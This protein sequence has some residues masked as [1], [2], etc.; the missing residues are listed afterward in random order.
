MTEIAITSTS[1]ESYFHKALKILLCEKILEMNDSIIEH[2]QEKYIKKRF[3]DIY[4][5]FFNGK[6][7]VVEIQN[8]YISV[9]EIKKRIKDYNDL[10]I[11]VLWILYG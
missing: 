5:K 9:S 1:S 2:S 10:G 7:V 4:F 6:E 3:A 11:Y 8:S